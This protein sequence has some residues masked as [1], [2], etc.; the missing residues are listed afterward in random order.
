MAFN[1]NKVMELARRYADKGQVDKAIKE[2]LRV[3]GE[4]PSDVRAWLKIGDLYVKKGA[5]RE[6]TDTYLRVAHFYS[7]QGFFLKAV[8]VYKQILKLNPRLVEVHLRLAELHRQLGLMSDA[9]QHFEMVAGHFHR[10][11][12]TKEAL[13]TVRQLV[14]L[15]PD[16]VATRIKLAELYSKEGMLEEAVAEFGTACDYLR[17]QQREDDFIKVAERLLWHKAD[18]ITLSRELAAIYLRRRDARRALQKLQVCFKAN[19]RDVETL[20]LL[21][22]AFQSL[23]QT[24]KTV[25][26]LKE[27]ARVLDEDGRHEQAADV[28]RRILALAPNDRDAQAFLNRS[29]SASAPA[30]VPASGAGRRPSQ[31]PPV[32][33]PPP[34]PPRHRPLTVSVPV[35][36]P[37]ERLAQPTGSVPLLQER[38]GATGLPVTMSGRSGV[39]AIESEFTDELSYETSVAGEAHSEAISK[40]LTETDVYV[41]YGLQDKAIEHLRQVFELDPVNVEARERLVEILVTQGRHP[42]AVTELMQLAELMVSFTPDRA[43]GYLREVLGMAPGY[44]PALELAQ[45]FGL[46]LD[47]PADDGM[48]TA[49]TSTGARA[50][51]EDSVEFIDIDIEEESRIDSD[52]RVIAPRNSVNRPRTPVRGAIAS[53]Q[54]DTMVLS[55]DAP[56]DGAD[57]AETLLG[58]DAVVSIA[59]VDAF[60]DGALL[61]GPTEIIDLDDAEAAILGAEPVSEI[62]DEQIEPDMGAAATRVMLPG[63]I[64]DGDYDFSLDVD[65]FDPSTAVEV[66]PDD[67]VDIGLHVT[68]HRTR[69]GIA[70]TKAS[71]GLDDDLDEADFFIAQGLYDAA[72]ELL[73]NLLAHHPG[74]PLIQAKLDEVDELERQSQTAAP[75]APW[76]ATV[77]PE[78]STLGGGQASRKPAVVLQEPVA[79]EDAD[80]HYNLGIAY[81]EMGLYEEAI[82]EFEKVIGSPEREVQCR[83]MMGLC[84]REHQ[85]VLSAI[86]QFKAALHAPRITVSEQLSLYYEIAISYEQVLNDYHEALYFYELIQKRD[87]GYR[88]VDGRVRACRDRVG[89]KPTARH[90]RLANDPDGAVD[91]LLA[92]A[93]EHS[94]RG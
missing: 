30:P 37:E 83:L 63:D 55:V 19:S 91:S 88:D 69:P 62:L 94:R 46:S 71:G 39:G 66:T 27:M 57:G 11:G 24:A 70:G 2:Y 58:A 35:Q 78:E 65:A 47:Q 86:N 89:R 82:Q 26:V 13:A 80:T 90:E 59:D 48:W 12:K 6:A 43:I 51:L 7:E 42:E 52:T 50:V 1:K 56:D 64:D 38:L 8:A 36:A 34:L 45:R 53:E 93:D 21:S 31:P 14:E 75:A 44:Q 28:H 3:V 4:E 49:E 81:K 29:A 87:P 5:K 33:P 18:N 74:H 85:E 10:E 15:A 54:A 67:T 23:E 84:Y 20:D 16:N 68:E 60:G 17:S 41:K 61:G 72:R 79:D 73:N 9:M 77:S 92:E 32:P 25:S 40:I 22:Q 76:P